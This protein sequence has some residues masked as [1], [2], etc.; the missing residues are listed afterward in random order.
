MNQKKR[1]RLENNLYNT[2]IAY[3]LFEEVNI[4]NSELEAYKEDDSEEK[5]GI[6]KILDKVTSP[7]KNKKKD[8]IHNELMMAKTTLSNHIGSMDEGVDVSHYQDVDEIK[9]MISSLFIKDNGAS[10]LAFS[11]DLALNTTV[12]IDKTYL[13]DEESLKR[14]S[15]LMFDDESLMMNIR[16]TYLY[17]YNKITEEKVDLTP[18]L[19]SGYLIP[20]KTI[21]SIILLATSSFMLFDLV[22]NRKRKPDDSLMCFSSLVAG[23][24]VTNKFVLRRIHKQL[25]G[26]N[27]ECGK[28]AYINSLISG[29][30]IY[31][32]TFKDKESRDAKEAL[33]NYIQ[34][35]D[36][37]RGDAEYLAFVEKVEEKEN[38]AKISYAN[39]CINLLKDVLKTKESEV[40][41]KEPSFKTA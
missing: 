27:R 16:K 18:V 3:R 28:D 19:L 6:K 13:R 36:D 40:K 29:L 31:N 22:K 30:I 7:F 35:V 1:N 10:L 33:S 20:F 17:T 2:L 5:K 26:I 11:L 14:L 12:D 32:F 23:G 39:R 15:L 21:Q 37:L 24:K 8:D 4:I 34:L 41:E 25:K 38:L 9:R